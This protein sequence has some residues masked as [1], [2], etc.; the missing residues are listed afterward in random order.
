MRNEFT[1][2]SS[3]LARAQVIG[4][5]LISLL[6]LSLAATTGS[7]IVGGDGCVV[8]MSSS[9]G[10][11]KSHVEEFDYYTSSLVAWVAPKTIE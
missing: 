9:Y 11:S 6:D 1:Y 5:I 4:P 2:C 7:S 3:N 8:G 10:V